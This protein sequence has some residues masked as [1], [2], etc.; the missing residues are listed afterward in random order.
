MLGAE[1]YPTRRLLE[2]ARAC[3]DRIVLSAQI[4]PT[5]IAVG[6]SQGQEDKAS[7]VVMS[8]KYR[9]LAEKVFATDDR[10][11]ILYDGICNLCNGGVNFMLDWDS[12]NEERG[13]FRF[14]ALQS[15]VG[16]ALL[17][18]SG[19]KPTDCNSIILAL[20]DGSTYAKGD[21]VFRIGQGIGRGTVLDPFAPIAARVASAVVPSV[22]RDAL[23][24]FVAVNRYNWFGEAPECRLWDDR[25]DERFVGELEVLEPDA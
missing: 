8:E 13:N 7:D 23:Y 16:H 15:D 11:I 21:A 25:F 24:D 18:R 3:F 10:P 12:P 20:K 2:R 17:T 14:A 22:L 4:F 9:A 19:S 5:Q 1:L 6:G